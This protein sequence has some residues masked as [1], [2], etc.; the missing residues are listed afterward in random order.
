V[1][2]L[3]ALARP[4]LTEPPQT[5]AT[6]APGTGSP[7]AQASSA[8]QAGQ[9]PPAAPGGLAPLVAQS[10][11]AQPQ[12]AQAQP[13]PQGAQAQPQPQGAQA[14]ASQAQAPQI[15]AAKVREAVAK[16]A[17]DAKEWGGTAGAMVIEV[18]SGTV[19]A[20]ADEHTAMNPASNAKLATAAAALRVLGPDHRFLTGIYGKL[21]G[22]RVATLVLRGF[23]DPTLTSAD[24]AG[25]AHELRSRGVR[26]VGAILVDQSYFDDAFVPP[27]F[28]QQP[29]EW[30]PFRAPVSA[31]AV[32][33]NTVTIT[34]RPAE[35]GKPAAVSLDPPGIAKLTGAVRTTK[36]GD[37]E[38]LGATMTASAGALS[39]KLSGHVPE[40]GDPLSVARR[41]EDPQLAAGFAL[42][43]ALVDA[44]VEVSGDVRQGGEKEK[45]LLVAHRSEPLAHVLA[46]LGKD[47]DNFVAEMV[48][49]ALAAEKKG[50][51]ATFAAAAEVVTG[52]LRA[53]GAFEPGCVV[54]NG[55]GLFDAN[56]TTAAATTTLL[57]T[58]YLD[59]KLGPELTTHLA[60]GGVDGTL[61]SRFKPW[62]KARAVRAKTGTLNATFAL[63]GYVLSPPGKPAV[64]FALFV[65]GA[66]GK[67]SAGR[68]SIDKVVDAIARAV[69]GS[70]P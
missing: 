51:P 54:A 16:L 8:A 6:A 61:R 4:G 56:R 3:V 37:P 50:R 9:T 69:W 65:N 12:G 21:S 1:L 48:F 49:K 11:Q 5:A 19:L 15:N 38:S 20:S 31:V 45:G 62:A 27:A 14:Q 46:K 33:A 67:A 42:R 60:V 32:N 30:A 35:A 44:G 34:A 25:L 29:N 57:R 24:V 40:G 63:S 23:G 26:K 59:S 28:A 43:A 41:L 7:G 66:P 22:D 68:A 64:A 55:S 47:S 36:K 2:G 13:Q 53:M 10:S 18:A 70:P 52:E 39:I 58:A 17:S